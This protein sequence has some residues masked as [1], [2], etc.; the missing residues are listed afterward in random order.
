VGSTGRPLMKNRTPLRK[1]E[2]KMT[3]IAAEAHLP[4]L[5]R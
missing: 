5:G 2:D 3:S 4:A 1:E